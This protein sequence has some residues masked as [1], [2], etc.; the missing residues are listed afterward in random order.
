L[1]K[2]RRRKH[3]YVAFKECWFTRSAHQCIN[4]GK[5]L[6]IHRVGEALGLLSALD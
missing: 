1:K 5:M 3:F 6:D 4:G 2:K